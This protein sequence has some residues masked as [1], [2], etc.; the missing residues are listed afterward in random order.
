MAAKEK[1]GVTG[2][3]A[4][5]TQRFNGVKVFSATMFAQRSELGETV[6]HWMEAHPS[7]EIADIVVAQSSDQAFHCI[8]I[9]VFY[10]D[11]AKR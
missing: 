4:Q 6:T 7:V 1:Q 2:Q 8:S 10:F 9:T 5:G 11:Q 3:L